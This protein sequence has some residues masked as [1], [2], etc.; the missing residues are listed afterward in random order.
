MNNFPDVYEFHESRFS[1]SENIPILF[2][3]DFNAVPH[4]DG[5]KSPASKKLLGSGFR[6]AFREKYPD[7]EKNPGVSHR[8]GSRIDQLYYKGSG[9]KNG[10]TQVLTTW[11]SKFPSDHYLIKSVFELDYITTHDD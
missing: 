9:L 2:A 7:V 4:T 1:Q 3:G 8:S 11:P 10:S 5:G 6:D